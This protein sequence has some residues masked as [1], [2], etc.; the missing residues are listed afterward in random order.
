MPRIAI[1]FW[2]LT[3]SLKYTI[4]SIDKYILNVLRE[5]NIDYDIFMHTYCVFSLYTNK[6]A[7]EKCISLDNEE[8]KLLCPNYIKIDN[9]DT[10]KNILNLEQYRTHSDPWATNYETVDNFIL[11]MYSKMKVTHLIKNSNIIYD[12]I[13]FMRPDVRYKTTLDITIFNKLNNSNI[14]IPNF[15]LFP[16]FNDRF[17]IATYNNGILYGEIF[18]YMLE[19]SKKHQL[20]SETIHYNYLHTIYNLNIIYIPFYFNRIRVDGREENDT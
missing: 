13:I 11:A 1:A 8:Y 4:N 16:K 19:Y 9:Q 7:N 12:Y 18:N 3:R 10:I 15:H 14:C 20:H 17:C 5:N 6:R 2:G